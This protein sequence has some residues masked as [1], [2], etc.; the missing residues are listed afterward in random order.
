MR[1]NDRGAEVAR[2]RVAEP[3]EHFCGAVAFLLCVDHVRLC[4]H[5]A[6]P[7]D[8]R[9]A[10]GL[11]DQIGDVFDGVLESPGLL[12]EEAA[13]SGCAVAV[14]GVVDDAWRPVAVGRQAEVL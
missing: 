2:H 10:V 14:C 11:G 6:S 13:R 3:A 9:R 1:T 12:V 5:A 7:G 4:E 8:L